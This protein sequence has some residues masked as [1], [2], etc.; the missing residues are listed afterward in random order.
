ME[1]KS[2]GLFKIGGV[3]EVCKET[4]CKFYRSYEDNRCHIYNFLS[5]CPGKRTGEITELDIIL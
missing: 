4:D 1:Y 5:F 3:M 2:V